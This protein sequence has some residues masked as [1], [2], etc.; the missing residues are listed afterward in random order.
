[1]LLPIVEV[2]VWQV[3]WHRGCPLRGALVQKHLSAESI[4][5]VVRALLSP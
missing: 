5:V 4:L 1:M 3:V 2:F